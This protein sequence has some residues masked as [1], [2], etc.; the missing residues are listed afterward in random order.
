MTTQAKQLPPGL[1]ET[2]LESALE[3]MAHVEANWG[4]AILEIK[5]FRRDPLQP[6]TWSL[7]LLK[8]W[9]KTP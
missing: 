3:A 8:E 5:L 4:P 6:V 9:R 7:K 2:F 1:Y